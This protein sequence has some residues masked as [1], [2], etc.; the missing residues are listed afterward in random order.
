ME[1]GGK[2]TSVSTDHAVIRPRDIPMIVAESA[3][4][5]WIK[6]VAFL[7]THFGTLAEKAFP[8]TAVWSFF[9]TF[10]G[11]GIRNIVGWTNFGLIALATCI[12]LAAQFL[13][14]GRVLTVRR[15]PTAV[16]AFVLWGSASVIW[17]HYPKET[18]LASALSIATTGAGIF[19][20][21][22]FP[23]HTVLK[24]LSTSL[25]W[26]MGLTYVI[27]AYAAIVVKGAIAPLYMAAWDYIPPS[28]YWT[29]GLLLQGGPI[30][31][32]FGNRNP[33]AFAALL[34]M[35]CLAIEYVERPA[36]RWRILLWSIPTLGIFALTRSATATVALIACALIFAVALYLRTLS[37]ERR[38]H[39]MRIVYVCGV[40]ALLIALIAHTPLTA[41]LGRDPDLTG[42]IEI[43]TRLIEIWRE[44]PIL[45]W[46]W[47]M[48]WAP[49]LP[50][51]QT[52]VIRPDGTP[53]M[54]AH[55][56]YIEALFQTGV[57]GAVLLVIAVL[58]VVVQL[59]RASLRDLD[60][61]LT[62]L[63]AA[64]LMTAM[65]I[66]SFSESR[67]LSEGNWFLFSAF[68]TWVAVRSAI[69]EIPVIAQTKGCQDVE[70]S[71]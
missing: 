42:R 67:L 58:W 38:K 3:Q 44:R 60:H 27:E 8:A 21:L 68:A 34:L 32:V 71:N 29:H 9:L 64:L 15:F 22:A 43:W 20:A 30:Q 6:S 57:V 24:A 70:E 52:L 66:Q 33:L 12:V 5:L 63:L 25:K 11:Q 18:L 40:A 36:I 47:I 69:P 46:G 2:K 45:G 17:S 14:A 1:K 35:I 23:L 19:I 4:I 13:A 62:P 26:M 65:F 28:Y 54:Q 41:A 10:A 7:R 49:W 39:V 51:F 55:N 53:T 16:S 48:Y 59:Y 50:M 37:T 56:A 31:G 61:D